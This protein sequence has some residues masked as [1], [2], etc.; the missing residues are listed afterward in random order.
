MYAATGDTSFREKAAYMVRVM[1]ECQVKLG[2]GYLSAFPADK[3]DRLESDPHRA[4]VPYY[5]IHKIL[6]GLLDVHAL[7]D[8]AQAL[9]VAARLSDYFAARIAKLTPAQVEAMFRTDYRALHK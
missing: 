3:F 1:A 6:A 8:N 7:C 9:E 2:G 5:T 4:S